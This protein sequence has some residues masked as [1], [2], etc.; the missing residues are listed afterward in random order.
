VSHESTAG[1]ASTAAVSEASSPL[2]ANTPN[3]NSA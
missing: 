1:S 2:I 3:E